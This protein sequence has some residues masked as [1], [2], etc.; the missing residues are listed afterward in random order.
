MSGDQRNLNVHGACARVKSPTT[1]ISTPIE[2]IQS[3]IAIQT[4]PSGN[5]D[6]NDRATTAA[7]RD[8]V[9]RGFSPDAVAPGSLMDGGLYGRGEAGTRRE[10]RRRRSPFPG[11]TRSASTPTNRPASLS[12]RCDRA[13]PATGAVRSGAEAR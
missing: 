1:R 9:P 13:A 2:R 11:G 10:Y 4:S 8:N 7:T 6:E 5:P 3:G 12:G